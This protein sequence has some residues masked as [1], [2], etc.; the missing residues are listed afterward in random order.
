MSPSEH[1]TQ[2][3][4]SNSQ[5]QFSPVLRTEAESTLSCPS[6]VCAVSLH[7]VDLLL[8]LNLRRCK[9][10]L[11]I[12]NFEKFRSSSHNIKFAIFKLNGLVAFGAPQCG[13]APLSSSETVA[14]PKGNPVPVEAVAPHPFPRVP[15]NYQSASVS[16]G[17]PIPGI[18]C[19]WTL[20]I[21]DLLCRGVGVHQ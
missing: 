16:V 14:S 19:K 10:V 1:Q 17:R 2:Q 12:T 5:L 15:G 8:L 18:P 3:I 13:T 4:L 11:F 20:L 9:S 7:P 21:W 6:A